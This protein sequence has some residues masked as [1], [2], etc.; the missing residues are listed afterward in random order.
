MQ[1]YTVYAANL[2]MNAVKYV[3]QTPNDEEKAW[4]GFIKNDFHTDS[5][6]YLHGLS[7]ILPASLKE[8]CK[9]S[10]ATNT[11]TALVLIAICMRHFSQY[12]E[13]F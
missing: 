4:V 6:I 10:N 3:L 2:T 12:R 13:Q 9:C 8:L 1:S 7:V 5:F 11:S